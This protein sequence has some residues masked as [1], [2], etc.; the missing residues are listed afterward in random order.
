MTDIKSVFKKRIDKLNKIKSDPKIYDACLVHYA[1]SGQ[2]AVDFI[3]D[4]M[5]TYDPRVTPSNI[6]FILF[7]KQEELIIWLH[8]KW[9]NRSNGLIEKTRDCGLTWLGCAF[10]VWLFIFH[11]GQSISWGSR[12][13][14]L[15]DDMGN[16]DSIFEKIRIIIRQLPK[17]FRPR[18]FDDRDHARFMKFTNPANGS[19]ITGEA[20]DNIGRGGR[21]S[22]YLKD[23]SA[24]YERPERIEAALSQN[25]DVKIDISTPNGNGNPFYRK[26]FGGNI[27]VFTFNWRDDP[28]K[29]EAWYRKQCAELDPVIV[30]QEI[31]IDYDASVSNSLVSAIDVDKA[32]RQRPDELDD[33]RQPLIIGVDPARFGD[34]R[35]A[36]VLRQG[37]VVFEPY[38]LQ[39]KSTT[40]VAGFV[41]QLVLGLDRKVSAIHVDEGGLGAGV[42]DQ[43]AEQFDMVY[44]I[45]FGSKSGLIEAANKRSEMW[46]NMKDWFSMNVSIPNDPA[47]KTDI[48]SLQYK[49]NPLGQ[50]VLER[51]E[52]AKKRGVKS[53]DIGDGLALTFA[54]YVSIE[55]PQATTKNTRSQH[56]GY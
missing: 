2:G 37:R 32:M 28:R 24:F 56:T 16:P 9:A 6:P 54:R 21:S 10:S 31:D 18:S 40:E 45:Q 55:Q 13:E 5:M 52:D 34:D 35:T 51:K 22:I 1:S 53:P 44:G 26:R 38:V 11:E 12:K 3:N 17:I 19:T 29:T 15:V 20:G 48:C 39:N 46:L 23:E 8:E 42:V 4:W 33:K 43:L 47:L 36:I 41:T 50:Y 25:S 7:P 30:A 49:Y 14:S 27:P